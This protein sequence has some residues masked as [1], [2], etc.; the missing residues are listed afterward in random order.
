MAAGAT[1]LQRGLRARRNGVAT[2][3]PVMTDLVLTRRRVVD[4]MRA[5][6]TACRA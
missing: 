5:T 6:V 3:T 2:V 1:L 4:H